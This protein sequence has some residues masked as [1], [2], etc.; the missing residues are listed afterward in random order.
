MDFHSGRDHIDLQ[1]FGFSGFAELEQNVHQTSAGL[2]IV[3]DAK[4]DILLAGVSKVVA[5]D[6]VFS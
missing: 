4:D 6:F 3:F 1:G 5:A 2:A